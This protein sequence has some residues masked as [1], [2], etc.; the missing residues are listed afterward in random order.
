MPVISTGKKR[1]GT[2]KAAG[3]RCHPGATSRLYRQ[4][5]RR[6]R[7]S[8]D[9]PAR[10]AIATES[11]RARSFPAR[12]GRSPK[13]HVFSPT[14]ITLSLS[15]TCTGGWSAAASIRGWNAPNCDSL[16]RATRWRKY[17]PIAVPTSRRRSPSAA[18]TSLPADRTSAAA[19]LVREWSDTVRSALTWLGE[20]DPVA[21]MDTS[22]AEDPDATALLDR[23][24]RV[25]G[26]FWYRRQKWR[27]AKSRT[28][29]EAE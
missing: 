8:G 12:R 24:E 3:C 15:V 27:D 17:W 14:A 19:E 10:R 4:R 5:R 2:G 23:V 7:R 28:E 16:R 9:L 6:A 11:P 18:P 22:R 13:R 20:A 1:R 29:K 26:C 25:E 21:S